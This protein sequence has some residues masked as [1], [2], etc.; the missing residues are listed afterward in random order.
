MHF[1]GQM[2]C[3]KIQEMSI[4]SGGSD[5]RWRLGVFGNG[6]GDGLEQTIRVDDFYYW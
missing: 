6:Q 2:N 5:V 3:L 4:W 1:R